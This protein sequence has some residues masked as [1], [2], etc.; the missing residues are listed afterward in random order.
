MMKRLGQH[1]ECFFKLLFILS[2]MGGGMTGFMA[3]GEEKVF[4]LPPDKRGSNTEEAKELWLEGWGKQ[5]THYCN[6]ACGNGQYRARGTFH[7]NGSRPEEGN[8]INFNEV[9]SDNYDINDI[10]HG[11]YIAISDQV[12]EIDK[13]RKN[14]ECGTPFNNSQCGQWIDI[15]CTDVA[16]NCDTSK[17]PLRAQIVDFCPEVHPDR[18]NHQGGWV[19]GDGN[20][21]ADISDFIW[22]YFKVKDDNLKLEFVRCKDK[23]CF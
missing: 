22:T 8:K 4:I 14:G 16:G 11:K 13:C 12:Q 15:K 6:K 1:R 10:E 20:T 17:A 18:N 7:C 2:L 19:C 9:Y 5:T 3:C 23:D 21:V